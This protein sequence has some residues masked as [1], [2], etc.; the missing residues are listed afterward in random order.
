MSLVIQAPKPTN[1]FRAKIA[2][3]ASVICRPNAIG[4]YVI[5]MIACLAAFISN[6]L[7]SVSCNYEEAANHWMKGESL[8]AHSKE[9][10]HGFLYLPHAAILHVP[11][12]I[13][14]SQTGLTYLG[15]ILWRIF[16]FS[17]F[18]ISCKRLATWFKPARASAEWIIALFSCLLAASCL[19]IGQ[20]T[21]LLTA[22]MLLSIDAWRCQKF[23]RASFFVVLAI[24][25]KPLAL[26]MALIYFAASGPMRN[27]VA[28]GIVV[29]LVSAFCFQYPTY[30]WEQYKDCFDMLTKASSLTGSFNWAQV[31]GMLQVIGLE[32]NHRVQ[33]GIRVAAALATVVLVL[34]SVRKSCREEQALWIL[35]WTVVYLLLFNPRTENSTYCMIGPVMGY[36]IAECVPMTR[37]RWKIIGLVTLAILM[38]GS[39]EIG[40]AFTPPQWKATWL[41]PLSCCCLSFFL[42]VRFVSEQKPT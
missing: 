36:L 11:F 4:I 31:F 3:L 42:L 13:V 26:V 19:R 7:R 32:V 15:D 38:A 1:S 20:S 22:L 35:I 18:A 16:S 39:N 17:I 21:I 28:A 2:I 14:S 29:L 41:A 6:P 9:T 5:V 23:N 24:A 33:T 27:R 10:G 34:L 25:V 30:V 40:K 37:S 8:Y 12:A